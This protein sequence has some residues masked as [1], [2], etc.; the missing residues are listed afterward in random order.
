LRRK[1]EIYLGLLCNFEVVYMNKSLEN[2]D[3][4]SLGRKLI[5]TKRFLTKLRNTR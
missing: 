3:V 4:Q 5:V 2:L 1:A